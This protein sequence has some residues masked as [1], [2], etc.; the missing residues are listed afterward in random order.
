MTARIGR[1]ELARRLW[2]A[3]GAL[4]GAVP[5]HDRIGYVGALLILKRLSDRANEA[6]DSDFSDGV[7][8]HAGNL[9]G[10]GRLYVPD[11]ARW[12]ELAEGASPGTALDAAVR[13]VQDANASLEG[14]FWGVEFARLDPQLVRRLIG[15][16]S[17]IRMADADLARP[18]VVGQAF[19]DLIRRTASEGR[20]HTGETATPSHIAELVVRLVDP[21]PGLS[22]YDPAC[23]SG[24]FLTACVR[25]VQA[26]FGAGAAALS[27]AGRERNIAAWARCRMNLLLH[28]LPV[29]GVEL[30]NSLALDEIPVRTAHPA[31][32]VVAHPPFA[33]RNWAEGRGGNITDGFRFG[34]PARQNGDYAWIQ[35]AFSS[36]NTDGVAA[37]LLPAGVLFRHGS[38]GKVRQQMLQ[39]GVIDGIVTLPPGAVFGSSVSSVVMVLRNPGV[40]RPRSEVFVVTGMGDPGAAPLGLPEDGWAARLSEV[41][42]A[43]RDVPGISRMVPYDEIARN[44]F[45]LTGARY[46]RGQRR[47][48]R[49]APS[50]L[51]E[52]IRS[53]EVRKARLETKMDELLDDLERLPA[54]GLPR[55]DGA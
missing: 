14:V 30:G 31:D 33:W 39:A 32:R 18:D 5:Q 50:Q 12:P 55:A 45:I 29:T 38:D 7:L 10:D 34:P 53:L 40:P 37:L 54:S 15:L 1:A 41:Y 52:R 4:H 42:L 35:H 48:I 44:E 23:G 47:D 3:S 6:A 49:R 46:V 51:R 16:F 8:L 20:G 22:I 11:R 17:D 36:L 13:V 21:R 43:R 27:L 2:E 26:M 25:H 9:R 19:E 24:S 28:G